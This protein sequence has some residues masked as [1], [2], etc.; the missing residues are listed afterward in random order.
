MPGYPGTD[1]SL[2]N[3]AKKIGTG[4]LDTKIETGT[5]DELVREQH[6]PSS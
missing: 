5:S 3:G 4:D 6:S 2:R 1:S